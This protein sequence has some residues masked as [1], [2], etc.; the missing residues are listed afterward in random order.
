MTRF[1][2]MSGAY[3][4][5]VRWP[6]SR[7]PAAI[8]LE[9]L[10]GLGDGEALL[11][12]GPA[13]DHAARGSPGAAAAR[14]RR[15]SRSRP[16]PSRSARAASRRG[17]RAERLQPGPSIV[18]S[19]LD[20]REE[21][22][23]DAAVAELAPPPRRRRAPLLRSSRASATSPPRAST[24]TTTRSPCSAS[25]RPGTPG[26]A[27][28]GADHDPLGA[29][30]KRSATDAASRRPPP[31]WIGQLTAA[32]I[33]RTRVEVAAAARSA[34]RRGRRRAGT[35]RR[36]PAQRARGVDAGRRRSASRGRSRPGQPHGAAAADVDRRV[37][38][39]AGGRRAG[40]E[41]RRSSPSSRRPA[42]LDFSGW[43]WTPKT[44]VALRQRRRS[45]RRGRR[46]PS[47]SSSRGRG[48][49]EWTK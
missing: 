15:S 29:G 22:A 47:T 34:R 42:A 16:R 38:D 20:R 11:V 33:L 49:N 24:E 9:G 40:A 30:A 4:A 7:H 19:D 25:S 23:A 10:L 6:W 17:H 26:R 32:A 5:G 35:R 12:Q 18:P 1:R 39:H 2:T 41:A 46:C 8:A 31:T 13:D 21:E 3:A 28:R 36:P 43:N 44:R 14:R 27:G 37:E 48:A 45:A